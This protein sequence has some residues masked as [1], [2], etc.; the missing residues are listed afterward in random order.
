MKRPVSIILSLTLLLC[1]LLPVSTAFAANG[2]SN[3][4]QD[5]LRLCNQYHNGSELILDIR[6]CALAATLAIEQD[7]KA[8]MTAYRPNGNK[9]STIFGEY[10]YATQPASSGCNW[11]RSKSRPSA[12]KLVAYWMDTPGFKEN[13]RSS[14]FTHTGIYT[15]YSAKEKCYYTVQLFTAPAAEQD[16]SIP[17]EAIAAATGNVTLRTGP[18]TNY[19]SQG[20]LDKGQLMTIKSTYGKWAD[21]SLPDNTRGYVHTDY[22]AYV[23]NQTT[24][25]KAPEF[26]PIE[27]DVP[28]L[29]VPSTDSG[30]I[31]AAQATTNVNVRKGPGSS[32]KK[33][34]RLSKGQ[35]VAVWEIVGNWAKIT[36]TGSQYGYVFLDYLRFEEDVTLQA[37]S[38]GTATSKESVNVR[39]GPGTSY[40]K[41]GKLKK[42]DTV[43][44]I[45]DKGK[46]L[47]I[48]W[49][50]GSAYVYKS[51]FNI[52]TSSEPVPDQSFNLEK[53]IQSGQ[54]IRNENV[55]YGYF[56]TFP[57]G[58]ETINIRI[59]NSADAV[60]VKSDIKAI[61]GN[62]SA[63]FNVIESALPPYANKAYVEKLQKEIEAG[64][65]RFTPAQKNEIDWVYSQYD[66]TRDK[67]VV[68][69][70]ELNEI[71][72]DLFKKWI[73]AWEY[74]TFESVSSLDIPMIQ[75]FRTGRWW[76]WRCEAA[77]KHRTGSVELNKQTYN[78]TLDV[79]VNGSTI[80]AHRTDLSECVLFVMQRGHLQPCPLGPCL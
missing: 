1:C 43:Q 47:Q 69:I 55:C 65:G 60:K 40:R 80:K 57:N 79:Q 58:K 27:N 67:F 19:S 64:V 36:C 62:D 21:V 8:Q 72:E 41:V 24:P 63:P 74:I 20:K 46:W 26:P 28:T 22:I 68:G 59:T 14:M 13:V 37:P 12:E 18:G 23:T 35:T 76:L 32:Y 2:F 45:A 56:I 9:W 75:N 44:V 10:G 51:Y 38:V 25:E 34:G 53:L 6:L 71:K 15:F 3:H 17:A 48:H 11:M 73:S 39:S 5:V 61:W 30:S 50:N 54:H 4:Q 77:L 52:V 31:G 78:R 29:D 49:E 42:G 33:L 7:G 70:C 66:M 16:T